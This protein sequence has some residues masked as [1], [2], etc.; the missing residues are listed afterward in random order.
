MKKELVVLVV[1]AL[2]A[3]AAVVWMHAANDSLQNDESSQSAWGTTEAL[4]HSKVTDK[5]NSAAIKAQSAPSKDKK[6]VNHSH[7]G[8]ALSSQEVQA[9][10]KSWWFKL[11]VSR[12]AH[13]FE[14]EQTPIDLDVTC[15][16]TPYSVLDANSS[17]EHNF[18]KLTQTNPAEK[19]PEDLFYFTLTQFWQLNDEYFQFVA[20]WDRDMPARYRYEFYRSK[21]KHF[22]SQVE[23]VNLPIAMPAM[24][25]VLS[26]NAFIEALVSFYQQQGAQLGAR[27]LESSINDP[28][29]DQQ[30]TIVNAKVTQ[31]QTPLFSC[32]SGSDFLRSY[33]H[34]KTGENS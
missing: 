25:D 10:D 31:W 7:S 17:V 30:I 2:F 11:P 9:M 18:K 16:S 13:F 23:S 22:N 14:E 21:D 1:I 5:K 12:N 4:N 3:V 20:L 33:C 28:E 6:D 34:C 15:E 26:T 19:Y 29:G 24:K 27:I 32:E 8:R